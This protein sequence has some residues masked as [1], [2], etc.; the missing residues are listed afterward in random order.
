MYNGATQVGPFCNSKRT[1][2][3]SGS[4]SA[5]SDCGAPKRPAAPA[6]EKLVMKRRRLCRICMRSSPHSRLALPTLGLQFALDL[7]DEAPVGALS[8]KLLRTRFNHP[9]LAKAQGVEAQG[10]LG[11]ML[12]PLAVGYLLDG[13]EG[14]VIA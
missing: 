10:V 7:L 9:H 4:G 1:F 3:V 8:D 5:R 6:K 11:V 14:I 13:L 2:G 12:A